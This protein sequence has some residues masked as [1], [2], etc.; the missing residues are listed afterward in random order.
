M[1]SKLI[2]LNNTTRE[3]S[4]CGEPLRIEVSSS[5]LG[6]DDVILEKGWSPFFYPEDIVTPY[7]YFALAIDKDL[8]WEVRQQGNMK[9]LK[10]NPGE[11]WMNPPWTSFTH[12]INEACF[13]IILAVNEKVMLKNSQLE[14]SQQPELQFLNNYNVNDPILKN[15]IETFYHEVLNKGSNGRHFL[16][17]LLKLFC[18]YYIQN[19][20]NINMLT[21]ASHKSPNF[22]NS[23]LAI[24]DEFIMENL[25]ENITIEELAIEVNMSKYYFLREFKKFTGNTPYQH[26]IDMKIS[27]AKRMLANS[28]KSISEITLALGFSDQSHFSNT[29]KRFMRMSPA[30]F[31]KKFQ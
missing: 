16:D 4:D 10:T 22:S 14:R 6:W 9:T 27:E 20:S 3:S 23:R 13:F 21:N 29:F 24:V 17:G 12:K 18:G 8:E 5:H 31:R 26:I 1:K 15:F 19:Y 28:N 25:E 30:S 7:F 11:I 2:F